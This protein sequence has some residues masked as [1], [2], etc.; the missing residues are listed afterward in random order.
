MNSG[1]QVSIVDAAS[2]TILVCRD[3]GIKEQKDSRN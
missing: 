3:I 1:S 2:P